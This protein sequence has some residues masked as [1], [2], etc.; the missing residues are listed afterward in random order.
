MA[1]FLFIV[2]LHLTVLW[3]PKKDILHP[4]TC[5]GGSIQLT[6]CLSTGLGLALSISLLV[7]YFAA[8]HQI[9]SR[10][11]YTSSISGTH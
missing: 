11:K 8:H 7:L 4:Q 5:P 9:V 2:L 6:F 1:P 10:G 3:S